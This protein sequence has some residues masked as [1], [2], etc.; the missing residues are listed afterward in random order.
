MLDEDK[1]DATNDGAGPVTPTDSPTA[2]S[3]V[4]GSTPPAV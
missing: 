1:Q 4:T 2:D 3:G